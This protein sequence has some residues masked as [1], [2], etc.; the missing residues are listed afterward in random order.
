M[1]QTPRKIVDDGEDIRA[2]DVTALLADLKVLIREIIHKNLSFNAQVRL[3]VLFQG[4]PIRRDGIL[5]LFVQFFI[6]SL[7]LSEFLLS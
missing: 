4:I 7:Y 1:K 6:T 2:K 5:T 3:V